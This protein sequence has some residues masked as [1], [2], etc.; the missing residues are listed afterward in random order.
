MAPFGN[1]EVVPLSEV[2][3]PEFTNNQRKHDD[4]SVKGPVVLVVDDEPL[5]A[6]TLAAILKLAGYAVVTAYSGLSALGLAIVLRPVLLISD[7]AMPQMNG[8]E[9][10][11]AVL[12]ESS[13]C[14]VLLFSGHA[15]QQDLAP[16]REAGYDLTLLSKPVHPAEML[17]HVSRSLRNAERS[18][19]MAYLSSKIVPGALAESA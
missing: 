18:K 6:D 3:T 9:L 8:I 2:P 15:T 14:S 12:K 1:T 16:A 4:R 17:K 5:V 7:V 19:T 11:I 10:A 13:D